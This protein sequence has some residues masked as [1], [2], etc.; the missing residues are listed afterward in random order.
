MNLKKLGLIALTLVFY[1]A[2]NG[3]I[4]QKISTPYLYEHVGGGK[5]LLVPTGCGTPTGIGPLL[6]NKERRASFYYDTC[7]NKLFVFSPKDTTWSEAGG[8]S[9]TF[10]QVTDL[11]S[12]TTN[13]VTVNKIFANSGLTPPSST[14][15]SNVTSP[16]TGLL[17]HTTSPALELGSNAT[18]PT[19]SRGSII[20]TNPGANEKVGT[21][22]WSN[23][24]YAAIQVAPLD[25]GTI[26]QVW[27]GTKNKLTSSL[28]GKEPLVVYPEGNGAWGYAW[29]P[30]VGAN[31]GFKVGNF[32]GIDWRV[33]YQGSP[34]LS[35]S[36]LF[37]VNYAKRF[38]VKKNMEVK[39]WGLGDSTEGISTNHRTYKT[40][41]LEGTAN[42]IQKTNARTALEN[43]LFYE[44][45][46]KMGLG[47]TS[48]NHFLDINGPMRADSALI[49][50]S[51]FPATTYT[52][53]YTP[54]LRIAAEAVQLELLAK[55]AGGADGNIVF[56]N[57]AA[58]VHLPAA[59]GTHAVT[60]WQQTNDASG[61]VLSLYLATANRQ[62]GSF[63]GMNIMNFYRQGTYVA[64][65]YYHWPTMSAEWEVKI[66]EGFG[67][68]GDSSV[69]QVHA[70][71]K[72]IVIK[73]LPLVPID[74]NTYKP[75]VNDAST[76]RS[77]RTN[78]PTFGSG[79]V[80][81]TSTQIGYGTGSGI[82]SDGNLTVT[83]PIA[84]STQVNI[85]SAVSSQTGKI[86]L[87]GSAGTGTVAADN[88]LDFVTT[89]AGTG[90]RFITQSNQVRVR[91]F[92]NGD[93]QINNLAAAK[94]R[95][96]YVNDLG[97]LKYQASFQ[98]DDTFSNLRVKRG[99]FAKRVQVGD[100]LYNTPA[101]DSGF[102]FGN[103]VTA[104]AG[105]HNNEG[106]TARVAA[107]LNLI[108]VNYG[109]GGTTM[110][111]VSAGD[112]SGE[113]RIFRIPVKTPSRKYLFE[114]YSAN[115]AGNASIDSNEF[116]ASVTRWYDS[117]MMAPRNWPADSIISV[118]PFLITSGSPLVSQRDTM[119]LRIKREVAASKGIR[120]VDVR[121]G[122][123]FN[124]GQ[125]LLQSDKVHPTEF[126]H[127]LMATAV[128]DTLRSRSASFRVT[129]YF[130]AG[131]TI[132]K[133]GGGN[134]PAVSLADT[135][136]R[137]F[138][139]MRGYWF[140]SFNSFFGIGTNALSINVGI[141][142]T[143][144]GDSVMGKQTTGTGNTGVGHF[145]LA[146]STTSASN[147]AVGVNTLYATTTGAEN[148]AFGWGALSSNTNGASNTAGGVNALAANLG[149][150][151]STAWGYAALRNS[152]GSNNTAVA[153]QAL[154]SNT[155]GVSNTAIGF[156][157]LRANTT[158]SDN[159]AAGN[160]AL[161]LNV[162]SNNAAFGSKSLDSCL[163]CT[164]S[165]ALGVEA[166]H[167][168]RIGTRNSYFGQ[169]SGTGNRAGN[170]N[171]IFGRLFFPDADSTASNIVAIADGDNNAAIYGS[172]ITQKLG[173]FTRTAT[174][175]L[176]INGKLRIRN[177]PTGS[178]S[179]SL[180]TTNEGVT[181]RV[182][183]EDYI[184][185]YIVT[186]NTTDAT[187]TGAFTLPTVI[188]TNYRLDVTCNAI[189]LDGESGMDCFIK[190]GFLRQGSGA[191]LARTLT[192]FDSPGYSG[193]LSSASFDIIASGT[194]I[195]VRAIGEA[196]TNI[197]FKFTIK[198]H[199]NAVA[200]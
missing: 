22:S 23:N 132:I 128:L 107:G 122:M 45:G 31:F 43:S 18:L 113:E 56:S 144:V 167:T 114:A 151:G 89:N 98:Y 124:G 105:V 90:H 159:T 35:D 88:S 28:A 64:G 120:F 52:R 68:L 8:G 106:W 179:D 33:G 137:H 130:Q 70:N 24:T 66:G 36:S 189:T 168:Q 191:L 82:T 13:N 110:S 60:A 176:D 63:N 74:T 103:S 85:G 54:Q 75:L 40:T 181:E 10:Q 192:P 80:S 69:F 91:I 2:V 38:G 78:W 61:A 47:T 108:E 9:G 4:Y 95:V 134:G 152:T 39:Q 59:W 129:G 102:F 71:S 79:G 53:G 77:Y 51:P 109:I 198:V 94:F 17:Y 87:G 16:P 118:G 141:R 20:W 73:T 165:V 65:K 76:G 11:G 183:R 48:P 121:K 175:A 180:L 150:F 156:E 99:W 86:L 115:D 143:A 57:S 26:W 116:R 123:V 199:R 173:I 7:A 125:N 131:P 5:S 161:K 12:T 190:R 158:T 163:T 112:S 21:S 93:F 193:S 19:A 97:I 84:G 187:P 44:I 14:Y 111:Q 171:S 62:I 170:Y 1:S 58:A 149:G 104:K 177:L 6:N 164:E 174:E 72:P 138:L 200:L 46:G 117:A 146:R 50:T 3:Q 27:I 126:G 188:A 140:N 155:S 55:S 142:N 147:T 29:V 153:Y 145:A 25:S 135:S 172:T 182:S 196:A 148:S 81:L 166:G 30:T 42:Y 34:Q 194:N 37:Q 157:S 119:F 15:G 49:N 178:L 160:R 92:D 32:A 139:E 67:A 136:G 41:P 185:E 184:N 83:V 195:V 127:E 169:G 133:A 100:S 154:F 186:V 96:P 197:Q 101:V 162:G